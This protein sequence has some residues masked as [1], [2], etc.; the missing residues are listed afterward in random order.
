MNR[1]ITAVIAAACALGLVAPG[2]AQDRAAAAQ[3]A[4]TLEQAVALASGGQPAIA[5][6]ERE[7]QA[8]EQAAIAARTLPDLELTL[9]VQNFPILRGD[10]AFSPVDDI[11][12][13][14]TIGIMREQVRRSR[15]EAEAARIRADALVSRRRGTAQQRQ[16]RRAAMIAWID[17]VEAKAK[18]RLLE[19]LIADL[20]SG[21]KVIGAAIPTGGSTPS[22][23]LEADSEIGIAEAEL[24]SA[25]AAVARARA[26]LARWIGSV[27]ASAPLPDSLPSIDAPEAA[28]A[29]LFRLVAHPELQVAEAERQAALRQVD[30]ARQQ[31]G[32]DISWSVLLGIRP[33]HGEMIGGQVSIPLRLNRRQRQ[34]RLVAEAQLRADAA[35]LRIEDARRELE[36]RYRAALAD[37]QGAGAELERINRESIPALE[38]AFEAAEARYAAGGGTLDQPFAIVR[39]YVETTVKS[40]EIRARRNR[41]AAEMLYVLG[42]T[43]Q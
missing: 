10:N 25:R 28:P 36:R 17:A 19:R 32:R 22:L 16:I 27:A 26:E 31:A 41:A 23:A 43:G 39:R 40:V 20:R 12:T 37:Y 42:E 24:A 3:P 38:S 14:Y 2:A 9:G 7:A 13:M 4:L 11:M 35:G 6:Y 18:Q 21:R 15:R 1:L 34:D 30:V 33:K 8:S 29:D 5:A